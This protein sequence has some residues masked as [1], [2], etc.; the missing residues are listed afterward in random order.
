MNTFD[1][2]GTFYTKLFMLFTINIVIWQKK[3]HSSIKAIK[4]QQEFSKFSRIKDQELRLENYIGKY[5]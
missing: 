1:Q 3:K 4:F 2:N 5:S